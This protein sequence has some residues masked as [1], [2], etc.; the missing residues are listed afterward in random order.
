MKG[1]RVEEKGKKT[2]GHGQQYGD[3]WGDVGIR[4][5][6]DN[7]KKYNKDFFLKDV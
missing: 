4:G 2:H 5:L 1:G 6:N 7:G 3:C